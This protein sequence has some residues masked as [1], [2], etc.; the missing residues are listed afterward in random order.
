M[1]PRWRKKFATI[2]GALTFDQCTQLGEPIPIF[3]HI[4]SR[5]SMPTVADPEILGKGGGRNEKSDPVVICHKYTKLR[6]SLHHD[7][8]PARVGIAGVNPPPPFV[9]V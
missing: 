6:I 3:A 8:M 2:L 1:S 7:A 9:H 4:H 5:M